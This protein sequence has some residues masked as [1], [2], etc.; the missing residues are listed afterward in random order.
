M[1][2]LSLVF[3]NVHVLNL[4]CTA[5]A[6]FFIIGA[7]YVLNNFAAASYETNFRATGV[8]MELSV[9]RVG[10][11]L[12]PSWSEPCSKSTPV[13]RR[14]SLQSERLRLWQRLPSPR[15]DL[16]DSQLSIRYLPKRLST[17]DVFTSQ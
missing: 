14:C 5:A 12:G 8:G 1:S 2:V 17:A 6:G 3:F 16:H 7:Q 13:Q 15:W 11:I 9:G 10:A 4:V